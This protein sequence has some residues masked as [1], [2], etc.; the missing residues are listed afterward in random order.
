VGATILRVSVLADG[1][2]LL[3]GNRVTLSELTAALDARPGENS[4]IWYH[5]ENA[6]GEAPPVS[7]EVMKLITERRLAVRLSSK[8]DFSDTVLPHGASA[9]EHVFAAIRQRAAQ[10]Q[11]VIHR[12][13]GRQLMVP[14]LARDAAPADSVAAV[15][16]MLPSAMKRNVA[17]IGETSWASA[18][19][20][21][22]RDAA[23]AIPFFGLL[24]GFGAIGHA[25]WI[26]GGATD[27][28]LV[29][30]C[31]D[32]DLVIVDGARVDT[33]PAGWQD[34]VAPV[35]RV[36]QIRVFDRATQELRKV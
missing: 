10:R 5:R 8:P 21:N 29:A 16:R 19:K 25:V 4:V 26:F 15:E 1:S 6:G 11:M 35:M 18:E 22:L 33:L 24:M 28:V 31:R 32:A 36:A 14:A 2:V 34:T 30:G 20:P 9:I 3:N 23:S 13:D 27:A 7:L 17:V 12:S